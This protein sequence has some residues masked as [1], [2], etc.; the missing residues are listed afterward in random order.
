MRQPDTT[1]AGTGELAN[2]TGIRSAAS[3]AA[4]ME[5]G[6]ADFEPEGAVGDFH[7]YRID[8]R[9]QM[10]PVGTLPPTPAGTA[11]T[12]EPLAMLLDKLGERLGFERT[13]ARLYETLLEKVEQEEALPGGPTREQ[14]QRIRDQEAAHFAMLTEKI[15]QLDGDPTALTPSADLA[16]VASS[17]VVKVLSDPRTTL[18]ECLE[19]I[20][21]AELV[22]HAG[23]ARLIALAERAGE[24]ELA[25]ACREAEQV[26]QQHLV[27]VHGWL[28]ALM[29]GN[30]TERGTPRGG[31]GKSG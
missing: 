24:E 23:W 14:L 26:E 5:A 21:I 7:R 30:R 4:E 13:G 1:E 17:G 16:A 18:A 2:R 29:P 19:A 9:A 25:R 15:Q 12:A 20:V 31:V 11:P 3:A 8:S 10:P 28:S 6:A 27:S 22:D